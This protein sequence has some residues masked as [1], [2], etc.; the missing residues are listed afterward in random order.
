MRWLPEV[1]AQWIGA[2]MDRGFAVSA[3]VD[4]IR[5]TGMN[6][7]PVGLVLRINM[8]GDDPEVPSTERTVAHNN[9][10][11]SPP[12]PCYSVRVRFW[13][14]N[15]QINSYGI[16]HGMNRPKPIS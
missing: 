15:G 5:G 16:M 2:K 9:S 3:V 11:A 13:E 4:R 12:A 1:K 7:S 10:N 6:G 8:E 14:P